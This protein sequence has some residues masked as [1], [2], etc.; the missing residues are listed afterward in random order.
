MKNKPIEIIR[1][2]KIQTKLLNNRNSDKTQIRLDIGDDAFAF[3]HDKKWTLL[4]QDQFIEDI[5]FDQKYFSAFDIGWKSLARN[6]SDLIAKG[7]TPYGCLVSIALPVSISEAWIEN[8]YDGLLA[9]AKIAKIDVA[10]GDMSSSPGKIYIDVSVYGGA[11]EVIPRKGAQI[12]D[13]LMT[14]GPLGLSH[15]GLMEL[16]KNSQIIS[17]FTKQHLRPQPRFDQLFTLEKN[18]SSIHSSIDVSD[19]LISEC[20]HLIQGSNLGVHLTSLSEAELWGGEDHEILLA[21]PD[22]K[23]FPDW[24]IL[25]Q[26]DESGIIRMQNKNGDLVVIDEYKGWN[27]FT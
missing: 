27:H 5:H 15:L 7:A 24:L 12:G 14:S 11:N 8:F 18:L 23:N 2:Q 17:A 3:S 1:L 13:F 22:T 19:G 20:L 25:G 9:L 16:Q 4:A 10:G 6:L 21:V 26:F